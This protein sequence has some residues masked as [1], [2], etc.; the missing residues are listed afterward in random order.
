MKNIDLIRLIRL[1][2]KYTEYKEKFDDDMK[3]CNSIEQLSE[4]Y[5]LY[6]GRLEGLIEGLTIPVK[7]YK[8]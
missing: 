5:A 6:T 1:H 4:A 8:K 2:D 3:N 7:H